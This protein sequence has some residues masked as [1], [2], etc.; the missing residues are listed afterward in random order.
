MWAFE[1]EATDDTKVR[2]RTHYANDAVSSDSY[3]SADYPMKC[4]TIS[5]LFSFESNKKFKITW[6]SRCLVI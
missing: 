2:I 1:R 6:V 4:T 3:F 5:K